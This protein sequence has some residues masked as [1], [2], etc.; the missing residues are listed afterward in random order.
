MRKLLKNAIDPMK[1][2]S[3]IEEHVLKGKKTLSSIVK[4]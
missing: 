3:T 2:P 1:S 4:V